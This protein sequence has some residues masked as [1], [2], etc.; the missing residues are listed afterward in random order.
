MCISTDNNGSQRLIDA[1]GIGYEKRIKNNLVTLQGIRRKARLQ[2][3]LY[4]VLTDEG[5][6]QELEPLITY[7]TS[8]VAVLI[9]EATHKS[10]S[11]SRI[12]LFISKN[13]DSQN[14]IDFIFARVKEQ[15]TRWF[16]GQSYL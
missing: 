7:Y 4:T 13:I 2:T 15:H 3:H 12:S 14:G 5:V 1:L 8:L 6:N 16:K 11:V 9:T 10:T